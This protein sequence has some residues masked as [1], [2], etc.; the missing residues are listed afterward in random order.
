MCQIKTAI[1]DHLVRIMPGRLFVHLHAL[2]TKL[3]DVS[4][5]LEHDK[6]RILVKQRLAGTTICCEHCDRAL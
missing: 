4:V 3:V 2:K 1:F 5:F 6:V